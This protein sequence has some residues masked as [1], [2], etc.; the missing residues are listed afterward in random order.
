[1]QDF[2]KLAKWEE[3]GYY[4]MRA[5]TEKAQRHLHRLTRNATVVRLLRLFESPPSHWPTQHASALQQHANASL[6]HTGLKL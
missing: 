3:R 6:E 1:M 4:A 2:V 5:S